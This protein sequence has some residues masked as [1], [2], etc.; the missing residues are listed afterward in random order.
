MLSSSDFSDFFYTASDGLRLHARIYGKAIADP[1]PIVCLAGL[2]RNARDFHDLALYLSHR[3]RPRRKVIAFDYRGR[4]QSSYDH[5]WQNYNIATETDDILTGLSALEVD[6]AAFIGTS[7]GGLVIHLLAAMRPSLLQAAVLNDIGPV[8]EGDGL[9]HIRAYL[10]NAPKPRD[11]DHAVTIQRAVHG[12]AF[13]AL[14][15]ADWLRFVSAI[16]REDEG[17]PVADFDPALLKTMSDMDFSEPLPDLWP[18]FDGLL[19]I[20]LLVIRGEN[21]KLL[22]A[23]TLE[24]M[25]R[26]HPAARAIVVPGQGHAPL[27]ETGDLPR[28]IARF[29]NHAALKA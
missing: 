22:S 18:Q 11:L 5:N 8:I 1:F 4:G 29:L 17:R 7:R 20:P 3:A 15:E 13:S 26:R 19:Q 28:Q 27:L 23:E 25:L 21:S 9:A 14:R 12:Q 10:E 24:E 2:T 16:Y 6:R